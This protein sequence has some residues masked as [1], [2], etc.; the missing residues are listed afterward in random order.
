MV[1]VLNTEELKLRYLID[2]TSLGPLIE[3]PNGMK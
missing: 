1:G 3:V 2:W